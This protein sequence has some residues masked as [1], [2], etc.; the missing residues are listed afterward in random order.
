MVEVKESPIHGHGVFAQRPFEAGRRLRIPYVVLDDDDSDIIWNNSF[1]GYYP[2]QEVPW[3]YLNHDEN[4]RAEVIEDE[5]G[6]WLTF[7]KDVQ[8][9][10]EITID[11]GDKYNWKLA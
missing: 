9:G 1:G 10:Q 11:Y 4:P 3:A 2:S 5:N 8:P 7:L 6:L